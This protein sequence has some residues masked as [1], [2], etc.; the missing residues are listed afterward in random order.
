ME[1]TFVKTT[2]RDIFL[3]LLHMISLVTSVIGLLVLLFGYFNVLFPDSLNF[4]LSD[5]QE[6][7]RIASSILIVVFPIF[8]FISWLMGRDYKKDPSKRGV[9]ARKIFTYITLFASAVTVVVDLIVL[10]YRFYSGDYSVQFFAKILSVLIV[11]AAVFGYYLWDIRRENNESKKPKLYGWLS[12]IIIAAIIIAGFFIVGSPATQRDRRFDETRI[13]NLQT[14][15]NEI[16][17]YWA[18]KNILPSTLI[19]LNDSISGF[20]VPS[21]PQTNI[22]YEYIIN[23]KLSFKLCANFNTDSNDYNSGQTVIPMIYP[24]N[25]NWN[26]SVGRVCFTRTID[27]QLYKTPR[28]Y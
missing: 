15:Q 10:I 21:D 3:H 1:N 7:I 20:S 6:Q 13:S 24:Y 23:G 27:P 5:Y 26:H 2:A 16:I 12:S 25:Q 17:N 9:L 11:A 4:Y 22:N 28:S 19:D 8:I 18:T 14:I